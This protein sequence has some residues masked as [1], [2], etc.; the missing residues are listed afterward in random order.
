MAA[1]ASL[2]VVRRGETGIPSPAVAKSGP[3]AESGEAG[4][5]SPAVAKSG[6]AAESGKTMRVAPGGEGPPTER[7][8]VQAVPRV[9]VGRVA[10]RVPVTVRARTPRRVTGRGGASQTEL[11]ATR[12]AAVPVLI[13]PLA[14]GSALVVPVAAVGRNAPAAAGATA[15][16]PLRRRRP[17]SRTTSP[18][19]SFLV[20]HA[21][22]CAGFPRISP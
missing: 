20:T 1:I 7:A 8:A 15:V 10:R 16:V 13:A 2:A 12:G 19:N 18:R 5:P 14:I 17:R 9:R 4:I 22:N 6:P 3:A 11:M 21:R